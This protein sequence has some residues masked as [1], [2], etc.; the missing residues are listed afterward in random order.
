V[1]RTVGVSHITLFTP[2]AP[3]GGRCLFCPTVPDTPK[4]YLPHSRI[5]RV[6]LTHDSCQQMRHWLGEIEA[7][8]TKAEKLEVIILGG[9]FGYHDAGFQE[10]FLRG[11]YRGADGDASDRETSLDELV[12]THAGSEG[13]RIIGITVEIR[14]DQITPALCDRLFRAGVTKIEMGAQCLDDAVLGANDRGHDVATIVA[15]TRII[16]NAGLKVGYH[17][18][19]GMPTASYEVDVESARRTFVDSEFQPDHLKIYFCEMFRKEFMRPELVRLFDEG[20]WRPLEESERHERLA[21]ILPIVPPWI[22]ISRIG[23]KSAPDE[24]AIRK[25]PLNRGDVEKRY[26]CR[27]IRCREP[28]P[29]RE[30]RID[31]VVIE[32]RE[33][34]PGE[35]FLEARPAASAALGPAP[36]GRGDCLGVLR[37]RTGAASTGGTETRDAIVRELHVYGFPASIGDPGFHQHRGIGRHLM[38]AAEEI[39]AAEGHPRLA[40]ASGVGVL[41]YYARLGYEVDANARMTKVVSSRVSTNQ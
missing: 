36:Q 33:V 28:N 29:K 24:F 32:R 12:E 11:I 4:S 13:H 19:L 35:V 38:A 17:L 15:A 5:A 37:L 34:G 18:L 2:P 9:S 30:A 22:R 23:R 21:A 41:A 40:V 31:K 10:E 7:R 26:G 8:G 16:K 39:A 25:I 14:P 27:C 6:N 3:C 1:R 20:R